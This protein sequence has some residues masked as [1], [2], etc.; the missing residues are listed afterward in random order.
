MGWKLAKEYLDEYRTEMGKA[1]DNTRRQRWFTSA[2]DS[3]AYMMEVFSRQSENAGWL[4]EYN[5]DGDF[6][7][8]TANRQR[9]A[10]LASC[11][12]DARRQFAAGSDDRA[13][14]AADI[15]RFQVM[16]LNH[17]IKV[18]DVFDQLLTARDGGIRELG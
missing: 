12:R 13:R 18:L 3:Y 6:A 4:D 7:K 2:S 9:V 10:F 17:S 1:L 16:R 15:D 8:L 11:A 14:T 5:A